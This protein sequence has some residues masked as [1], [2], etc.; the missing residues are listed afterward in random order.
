[1]SSNSDNPFLIQTEIFPE[2]PEQLRI[3]LTQTYE[4]T[5][6]KVNYREISLYTFNEIQTGRQYPGITSPLSPRQGYRK[7]ID[8]GTLSTGANS[9]AHSIPYQIPNTL[10]F[11]SIR[12]VCENLT[13]QSYQAMPNDD[14]H[15]EVVGINV[16]V[17][18]PVAYNGFTGTV[19]LDYTVTD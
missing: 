13:T 17:T 6:N 9:V 7:V 11:T 3:R 14:I 10:R 12:G 18:I 5:S 2:D 19:Y 4:D 16:V 1:V 8:M 15:L